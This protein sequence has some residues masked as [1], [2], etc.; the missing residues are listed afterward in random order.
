MVI[1]IERVEE[2][3]QNFRSKSILVIGALLSRILGSSVSGLKNRAHRPIK[4]GYYK[5]R[6]HAKKVLA[7]AGIA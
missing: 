5:L 2:I 3:L 7:S 6:R 4:K 1:K